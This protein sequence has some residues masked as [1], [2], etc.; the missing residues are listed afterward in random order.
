MRVRARGDATPNVNGPGVAVKPRAWSPE[1]PSCPVSTTVNPQPDPGV[2]P[3][4]AVG[5]LKVMNRE[6]A[7]ALISIWPTVLPCAST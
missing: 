6:I 1:K 2:P 5:T 7:L 4:D 3:S